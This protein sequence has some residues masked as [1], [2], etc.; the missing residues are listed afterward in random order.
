MDVASREFAECWQAA[1]RHL[2]EQAEHGPA[3]NLRAHVNPPFLEHLSFRV[4]NQLFFV[5][6]Q[7]A[8]AS[9]SIPGS[10][11]GLL[12]IADGCKGHPCIMLMRR[13]GGVWLPISPSWGWF[14]PV[15][16]SLCT[17]RLWLQPNRLR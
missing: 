8:D 5:R 11:T 12:A 17:R 13:E 3:L 4:G 9:L 7:D 2:H 14:T 10:M 1:G 16:A 6:I 15:L